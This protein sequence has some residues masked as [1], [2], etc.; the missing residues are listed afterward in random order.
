MVIL[1]IHKQILA[2]MNSCAALSEQDSMTFSEIKEI[3]PDIKTI[4]L[5]E[6]RK[7]SFIRSTGGQINKYFLTPKGAGYAVEQMKADVEH[8]VDAYFS[9]EPEQDS[10]QEA[11]VVDAEITHCKTI[12]LAAAL[13]QATHEIIALKNELNDVMSQLESRNS[14][15]PAVGYLLGDT[16]KHGKQVHLYTEDDRLTA[17]ESIDKAQED[18]KAACVESAYDFAVYAL[19]PVGAFKTRTVVEWVDAR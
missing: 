14:E 13:E 15:M 10:V 16:V 7:E 5:I 17:Y 6:L 19:V 3:L 8:Y 4:R 1:D 9:P 12:Q 11:T 18:G 2:A